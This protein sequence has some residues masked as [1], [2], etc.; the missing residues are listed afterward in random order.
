IGMN[1]F[2]TILAIL[3]SYAAASAQ[4]LK[5]L[6]IS[7][8]QPQ[9]AIHEEL[10]NKGMS[11]IASNLDGIH[12]RGDFW[13]FRNCE[14][15]V[16]GKAGSIVEV[17]PPSW[18]TVETMNDLI[19]SLTHKYGTP[20]TSQSSDFHQEFIWYIGDNCIVITDLYIDGHNY[21]IGYYSKDATR[22]KIAN[23]R[24]YDADL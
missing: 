24:Y 22:N 12:M 9:Q 14:L 19:S 10:L 21:N 17:K 15:A 6:G 3:M 18:V 1:F 4:D 11:D 23:T 2:L 20:D 16:S 7:L 5:F 13:K 8:E